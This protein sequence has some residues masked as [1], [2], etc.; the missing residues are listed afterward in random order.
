MASV[1]DEY[2]LE[3]KLD[4]IV[5]K[6]GIGIWNIKSH[7]NNIG[8]TQYVVF[9]IIKLTYLLQPFRDPFWP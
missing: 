3:S 4:A 1:I 2:C 9:A 8:V 6:Q 7:L 5:Q